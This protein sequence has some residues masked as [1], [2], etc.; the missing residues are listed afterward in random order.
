MFVTFLYVSTKTIKL[1]QQQGYQEKLGHSQKKILAQSQELDL[2]A[3][4]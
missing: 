3:D 2:V 1:K 4:L